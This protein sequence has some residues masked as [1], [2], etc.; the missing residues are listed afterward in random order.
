MVKRYKKEIKGK[1][2][3]CCD[4][5]KDHSKLPVS[6]SVVVE[7]S[8]SQKVANNQMY[9]ILAEKLSVVA[10]EVFKEIEQSMDD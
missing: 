7:K 9:E 2:E 4:L 10:N 3:Q 8:V 6:S 1:D 5:K